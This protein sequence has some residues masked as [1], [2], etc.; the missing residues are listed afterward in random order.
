MRAMLWAL[1]ATLAAAGAIAVLS[2]DNRGRHLRF[3]RPRAGVEEHRSVGFVVLVMVTSGLVALAL[4]D[5]RGEHS[6]GT[7]FL[8][9]VL[10]ALASTGV[11]IAL[12]NR[13]ARARG[14]A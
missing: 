11:G 8:L 5:L 1:F 6:G 9:A 3:G 7:S 10:G 12:H 14:A 4:S 2:H 13:I